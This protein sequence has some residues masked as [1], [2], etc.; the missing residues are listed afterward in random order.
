MS[1]LSAA[2]ITD[3]T[4]KTILNN[5]GSILQVVSVNKTNQ[6][7]LASTG[8]PTDVPGL[9]A[10]ITPYSSSSNI[11]VLGN[12]SMSATSNGG[13]SFAKLLRN[14]TEVGSGSGGYF[15]QVA[16]QDY[17]TVQ[18]RVINLVDSP[19]TTTPVTYKIQVWGQNVYVNGR[20]ID[21]GFITSSQIV[22]LEVSA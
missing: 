10:T 18:S 7:Y 16:G 12:I 6:F 2:R 5:T 4:G 21:G 11:L 14:T 20:G 17:F 3:L 15:A 22:L 13:D 19:S 1:T 9:S 8:T